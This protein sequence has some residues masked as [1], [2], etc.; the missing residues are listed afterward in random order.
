MGNSEVIVDTEFGKL[1]IEVNTEDYGP[2][3]SV[4]VNEWTVTPNAFG[5]NNIKCKID[6]YACIANPTSPLNLHMKVL[7]A[8]Y[9]VMFLK[10]LKVKVSDDIIDAAILIHRYENEGRPLTINMLVNDFCKHNISIFARNDDM[11]KYLVHNM[12]ENRINAAKRILK[13]CASIFD[14]R[15]DGRSACINNCSN[16][17]RQMIG[18]MIYAGKKVGVEVQSNFAMLRDRDSKN[19]NYNV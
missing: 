2:E 7:E 8:I 19:S 4:I 10:L 3:V 12:F 18:L 5:T 15:I 1:F 11:V 16:Y 6:Y 13:E 9:K 14:Y 17:H